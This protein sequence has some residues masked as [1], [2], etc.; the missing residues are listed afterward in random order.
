MEGM[1]ME[2][3]D[4]DRRATR[5]IGELRTVPPE[6]REGWV[7]TIRADR[8]FGWMPPAKP[9]GLQPAIP[10]APRGGMVWMSTPTGTKWTALTPAI[11]QIEYRDGIAVPAVVSLLGSAA[12]VDVDVAWST[13]FSDDTYTIVKPQVSTSS[14]S[15]LGR[16]DAVVKAGSVT[17]KGCKVTV[18]TTALLSAGSCTVSVLAYRR[19]AQ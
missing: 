2:S 7:L 10:Q 16:T 12:T 9:T 3:P 14:A 15:L 17:A 13:P 11:A 8:T 5:R 4:A 18:T 1:S 6:A 19:G